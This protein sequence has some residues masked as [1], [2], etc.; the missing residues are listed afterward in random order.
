M[1]CRQSPLLDTAVIGLRD[2]GCKICTL[3][4]KRKDG[5]GVVTK[6]HHLHGNRSETIWSGD[7]SAMPFCFG[8]EGLHKL[9]VL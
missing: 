8:D 3:C 2:V 7:R 9:S 5:D 6:A 4:N 1:A